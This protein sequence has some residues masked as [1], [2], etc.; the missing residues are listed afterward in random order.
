MRCVKAGGILL[1]E[2][3]FLLWQTFSRHPLLILLWTIGVVLLQKGGDGGLGV[4]KLLT[5]PEPIDGIAYYNWYMMPALTTISLGTL[6]CFSWLGL[7]HES[8]GYSDVEPQAVTQGSLVVALGA[9]AL[10]VFAMQSKFGAGAAEPFGSVGYLV[11]A[12]VAPLLA[13]VSVFAVTFGLLAISRSRLRLMLNQPSHADIAMI[14]IINASPYWTLLVIN[15]S[16]YWV[17]I[18]I[19]AVWLVFPL[20]HMMRIKVIGFL[21]LFWLS[22]AQENASVVLL[23]LL[24]VVVIGLCLALV[25]WRWRTAGVGTG[26]LAILLA[27]YGPAPQYGRSTLLAHDVRRATVSKECTWPVDQKTSTAAEHLRARLE[28]LKALDLGDKQR[29]TIIV[30]AASG[31]G[32]RA[33]FWT[34]AVLDEIA[35]LASSGSVPAFKNF[36]DRIVL[37]TGASGGMVTAGYLYHTLSVESDRRQQSLQA[38]IANDARRGS[39]Q[40]YGRN[41][42]RPPLSDVPPTD[43]IDS[44]SAVLTTYL[45]RDNP[46]LPLSLFGLYPDR[47]TILERQWGT[48]DQPLSS[49][50][51]LEAAGAIP[52]IVFSPTIVGESRPLI[53]ASAELKYQPDIPCAV[54]PTSDLAKSK[55]TLSRSIRVNASFPRISNTVRLSPYSE[56]ELTDAGF[57]DNFG[58]DT[59]TLFLTQPGVRDVIGDSRVVLIQ[60]RAFPPTL[61]S[62]RTDELVD[63]GML[64]RLRSS[65]EDMFSTVRTLI[66]ALSIGN[67]SRAD[68]QVDLLKK[69]FGQF[70][71]GKPRLV[72]ITF[73]LSGEVSMSWY[74]TRHELASIQEAARYG[75][76]IV[77]P[78]FN[79]LQDA[80]T[81]K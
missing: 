22:P 29:P 51:A 4:E 42:P 56:L 43:P 27:N 38:Q 66:S 63:A 65:P 41:P 16:S 25:P 46:L 20:R 77:S 24:M 19:V 28:R 11:P 40:F 2:A 61:M 8:A 13:A 49:Y 81:G 75:N 5:D 50:A 1:V 47:G 21:L 54:L 72:P 39:D 68:T 67:A 26:I 44:L 80:L 14:L 36:T 35:R 58:I 73:S 52:A 9:V 79:M 78:R 33:A 69:S 3:I 70:P 53:I 12:I 64:V 7:R 15:T 37:L 57:A 62:D 71:D 23:A 45:Y 17:L 10:L 76:G 55:L 32:Y 30:I 6:V 48:L 74:L 34:A 18:S 60:M 31:G 59:A